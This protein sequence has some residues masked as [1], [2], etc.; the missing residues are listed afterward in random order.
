MSF[1]E[2]FLKVTGKRAVATGKGCIT[3]DMGG[4]R[5]REEMQRNEPKWLTHIRVINSFIQQIACPYCVLVTMLGAEHKLVP[6]INM[7][8][9]T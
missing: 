8:P 3:K 2:K 1:R 9:L 5:G 6:E 4:G 7:V